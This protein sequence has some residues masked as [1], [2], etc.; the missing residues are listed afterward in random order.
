VQGLEQLQVPQFEGGLLLYLRQALITQL[1]AEFALL[2][3]QIA[4]RDRHVLWLQALLA[5][6]VTQTQ[7]VAF[8]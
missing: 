3:H 8:P 1:L 5:C 7:S 4:P 6:T 2:L